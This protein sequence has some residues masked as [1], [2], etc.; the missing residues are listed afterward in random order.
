MSRIGN[1]ARL[2]H[3]LLAICDDDTYICNSTVSCY[4]IM[5][6][7]TCSGRY[8]IF[9]SLLLLIFIVLVRT[10]SYNSV[11]VSLPAPFLLHVLCTHLSLLVYMTRPTLIPSVRVCACV[12]I[13]V[14]ETHRDELYHLLGVDRRTTAAEI[15]RAYRNKS[16]RMHP[17]KLNQRGQEVTDEDKADFQ[18][19]KSAYDVS[20]ATDTIVRNSL[21]SQHHCHHHVSTQ[22]STSLQSFF[23]H[24]LPPLYSHF[25]T[26]PSTSLQS[27]SF[28]SLSRLC[29][30]AGGVPCL[31][32][33]RCNY[34]TS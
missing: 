10:N 29:V 30:T 17:D 5:S 18:K 23:Q 31:G 9:S 32:P 8:A 1:L 27:F 14:C 28:P 12:C 26:R 4:N 13:C 22:P 6:S 21:S 33:P 15:K 11:M 24:S 34:K 2:I 3:T 20:L 7:H 25:S 16:L 19:M